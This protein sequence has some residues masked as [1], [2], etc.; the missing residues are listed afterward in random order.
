MYRTQLFPR[1]TDFAFV[2]PQ[3]SLR[4]EVTQGNRR[5][6]RMH[7]LIALTLATCLSI[8]GLQ[9]YDLVNRKRAYQ[10]P[11]PSPVK[12][13]PP[14]RSVTSHPVLTKVK[15]EAPVIIPAGVMAVCPPVKVPPKVSAVVMPVQPKPHA[16]PRPAE[17]P[18]REIAPRPRIVT[19]TDQ[20]LPPMK[21]RRP[22]QSSTLVPSAAVPCSPPRP[23][24]STV[25]CVPP[26]P[27]MS[28]CSPCRLTQPKHHILFPRWQCARG[29]IRNPRP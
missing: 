27:V 6:R 13:E 5:G 20:P 26:C 11:A 3:G 14:V 21:V 1:P 9:I 8:L 2:A 15:A 4:N 29:I 19:K 24:V 25:V 23:C 28:E 22:E 16:T 18:I 17:V 10:Q 7:M 12:S